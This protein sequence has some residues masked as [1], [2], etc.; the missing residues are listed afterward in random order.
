MEVRVVDVGGLGNDGFWRI[1]NRENSCLFMK[2]FIY[3]QLYALECSK[4]EYNL[5]MDMDVLTEGP[6]SN[7]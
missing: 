3:N 4:G 5:L 6:I 1:E 7:Q 2:L